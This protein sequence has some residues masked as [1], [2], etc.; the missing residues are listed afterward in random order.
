M[1][2]S[3][4]AYMR[5]IDRICKLEEKEKQSKCEHRNID[6]FRVEPCQLYELGY[7]Q[8]TCK[9]CGLVRGYTETDGKKEIEKYYNKKLVE[10]KDVGV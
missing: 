7:I 10:L 8:S 5:L 3:E 4:K 9:E 6:W 2:I 1:W